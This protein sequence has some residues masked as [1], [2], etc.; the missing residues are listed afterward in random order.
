MLRKKEL[1]AAA[2][3]IA[4]LT[5]DGEVPAAITGKAELGLPL[6]GSEFRRATQSGVEVVELHCEVRD[7]MS[8]EIRAKRSCEPSAAQAHFGDE[9]IAIPEVGC[10]G[11]L[12]PRIVTSTYSA[13]SPPKRNPA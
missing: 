8:T 9:P 4:R 6:Q 7:F 1:V 2:D 12:R 5:I 10:I 3:L 13:F 11:A